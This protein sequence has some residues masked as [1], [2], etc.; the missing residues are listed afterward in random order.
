[1][2]LFCRAP[3]H[4]IYDSSGENI[5]RDIS[6]YANH[7]SWA[8]GSDGGTKEIPA[9]LDGTVNLV[10]TNRR[11]YGIAFLFDENPYSYWKTEGVYRIELAITGE[12]EEGSARVEFIDKKINIEFEYIKNEIQ[13]N[14]GEIVNNSELR[15]LTWDVL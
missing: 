4:A 13:S 10:K 7:F 1:M 6:E 11:G 14:T 9:E 3:C 12:I 2:T 8:G 15:L 5:K